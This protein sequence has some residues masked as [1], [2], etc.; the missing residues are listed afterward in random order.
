MEGANLGCVT[1]AN[2]PGVEA[3]IANRVGQAHHRKS[4]VC[5]I[6]SRWPMTS[7]PTRPTKMEES[8]PIM[9]QL[10]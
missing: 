1:G 6:R 9:L 3:T 4:S 2:W 8:H 7:K 5:L 10:S